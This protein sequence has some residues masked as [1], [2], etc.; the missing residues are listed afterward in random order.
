MD[1]IN[2][3]G[4]TDVACLSFGHTVTN[5]MDV[6]TYASGLD[7]RDQS[8]RATCIISGMR[9]ITLENNAGFHSPISRT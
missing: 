9:I 7:S 6:S 1:L 8:P 4:E 3:G 5:N 2:N